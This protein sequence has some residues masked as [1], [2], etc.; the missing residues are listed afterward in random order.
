MV[1]IY[2]WVQISP[3][4]TFS[5]NTTS[6]KMKL[7]PIIAMSGLALAIP[8]TL[9]TE[10]QSDTARRRKKD[11]NELAKEIAEEASPFCYECNCIVQALSKCS[12]CRKC[13]EIVYKR[14]LGG[15]FDP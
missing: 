13:R 8:A 10:T 4:T 9:M 6:A 14:P 1:T 7:F 12:Q 2:T 15:L 11:P 3:F 5:I